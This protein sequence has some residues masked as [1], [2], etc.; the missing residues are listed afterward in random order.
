[1]CNI[2]IS[3]KQYFFSLSA[4]LFA[5]S[6]EL[7]EIRTYKK[8]GATTAEVLIQNADT[9]AAMYIDG[10]ENAQFISE[11]LEDS[12]SPL[13]KLAKEIQDEMCGD[14]TDEE[15]MPL[16]YSCG[17]VDLS[18]TVMT[19]YGRG[20]W[21]SAGASYTFFMGFRHAGTGRFFESTHM[22]TI[23]ESVEATVDENYEPNGEMVK[24]LE[25][26][27][28]KKLEVDQE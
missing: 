13:S 18:N 28:I 25:F 21:M 3:S 7:E 27:K 22:I 16:D 11:L 24:Y 1:L 6:E 20:G 15:D 19:S 9:Q 2:Y 10:N 14:M 17:Y 4:Q 26:G 5:N 8:T 12:Q 23:H